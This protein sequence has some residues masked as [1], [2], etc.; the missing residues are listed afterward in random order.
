MIRRDMLWRGIGLVL[1]AGACGAAAAMNGS[2]QAMLVFPIALLGL[3]L[4]ING[5][6]V[7]VVLRAERHGHGHTA[8]AI[9]AVRLR[10]TRRPAD[11]PHSR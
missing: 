9:H 7:A 2:A 6:R 8:Q 1:A 3:T 11:P 5:K 4:M 10:R